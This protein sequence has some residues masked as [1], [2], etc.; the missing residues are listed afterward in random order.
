MVLPMVIVLF[1]GII[2][3]GLAISD[4]NSLRQGDREGVRR[5]VVADVG[6][7]T[8]CPITGDA[9]ND[10]TLALV[11]LSKDKIGLDAS[12]TKIAVVLD[13]SYQE[14]DALILCAQYPLMSR[15]GFFGFI[16]DSKAVHSQVD[17]RIE[18]T[19]LDIEAYAESGGDEWSWC[20]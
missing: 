1:M 5:A 15:T 10:D 12:A 17:M 8:T 18:K 16:L 14:G 20:G 9:P 7:D 3:F 2:D 6:T 13:S 19:T 4:Y 11:C